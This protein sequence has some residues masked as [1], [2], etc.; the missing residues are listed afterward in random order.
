LRK[1]K[2]IF[3]LIYITELNK[4]ILIKSMNPDN[5][6]IESN[7]MNVSNI[8]GV[9]TFGANNVSNYEIENNQTGNDNNEENAEANNSKDRS[10]DSYD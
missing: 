4:N 9:D 3:I 5:A 8:E 1:I 2:I 10:V 6:D 7:R